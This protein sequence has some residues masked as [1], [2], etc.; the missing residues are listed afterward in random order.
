MAIEEKRPLRATPQRT[1]TPVE[2]PAELTHEALV[3]EYELLAAGMRGMKD[4]FGKSRVQTHQQFDGKKEAEERARKDQLTGLFNRRYLEERLD[5]EIARAWREHTPIS[6]IMVDADKFK[7]VND[8]LGH[9]VG[10]ETLKRIAEV[11]TATCRQS[12]VP[13]RYGGEEFFVVL[14]DTD[15]KGALEFAKRLRKGMQ[16]TRFVFDGVDV[17]ANQPKGKMTLSIGV[18]TY[19]ESSLTYLKRVVGEKSEM[20]EYYARVKKELVSSADAATYSAKEDGRDCIRIAPTNHSRLVGEIAGKLCCELGVPSVYKDVVIRAAEYHDIGKIRIPDEVLGKN[21]RLT[22]GEQ[23]IMRQHTVLGAEIADELGLERIKPLIRGHHE[24]WDGQGYPN[25]VKGEEIPLG[26]RI[27]AVA[28]TFDAMTG[29]GGDRDYAERMS[30]ED[31]LKG[32]DR[33]SGTQ[34][35]PKVVDALTRLAARNEV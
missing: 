27:I 31:A 2:N 19:P 11:I 7:N 33:N 25:N 28:D 8:T 4:V 20:P 5:Q 10:D 14:P 21:G 9:Q 6:V 30:R 22:E 18:S 35:D 17:D 32:I 1:T 16:D 24:R 23:G 12:D 13:F 26:A 34:F 15:R 29:N 3:R